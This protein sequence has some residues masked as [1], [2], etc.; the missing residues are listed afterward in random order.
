LT[1]TSHPDLF[2]CE[3]D[4]L[5]HR[6]L[7]KLHRKAYALL[8]L[9]DGSTLRVYRGAPLVSVKVQAFNLRAL[10]DDPATT[11]EGKAIAGITKFAGDASGYIQVAEAA[12]QLFALLE[13][14]GDETA[15][16]L[17]AI[18]RQI[19]QLMQ[20]VGASDY[21]ALIRAMDLM[22]GNAT[23]LTQMLANED[24]RERIQRPGT[25]EQ[26]EFAQGDFQL[27]SDI[28]AL[29]D[30]DEGFFRRSYYEALI[31]GDGNWE[32]VIPDRPVDENGAT[33]EHR[34]AMPTVMYLIAVRLGTMKFS[35]P[36]FVSR[37]TYSVEIDN[38][39]RRIQQLS[40]QMAYYV[41]ETPVAP[42]D[43]QSARRFASGQTLGSYQ[44]WETHRALPPQS[45]LVPIG[46]ID[47]T[48]GQ[49]AINWDYTQFD[50]WYLAQ[51]DLHGR[52]AGY[53]PPSI[54]PTW[55][56]PPANATGLPPM[57]DATIQ[58]YYAA[59]RL[60]AVNSARSVQDQIGVGAA[61]QF[62]W[63][64]FDFAYPGAGTP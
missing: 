64:M 57:D 12:I 7:G 62:A 8:R 26:L 46:A 48:T 58:R 15:R 4:R 2:V 32:S 11:P 20:E 34:L 3:D 21:L 61:S 9:A 44:D 19:Q 33:F 37:G 51:G 36:D 38:W 55:Y 18:S 40:D 5:F 17:A 54:G 13:G 24:I 10:L 1:P 60:D 43:V 35:T 53:W 6:R 27:H 49:G 25:L 28:N 31:Q 50:E 59:A 23:A 42:I 16:S 29:L 41:R 47:I 63:M 56:M 22:R 30:P 52:N 14:L 45:S 39:W